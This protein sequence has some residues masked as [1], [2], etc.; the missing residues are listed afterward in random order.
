MRS[1]SSSASSSAWLMKTMATPFAFSRRISAKKW[2]FSS[3]VRLAVG[4]SKMMMRARISTARAI[5]TICFLA[6]PREATTA[7]GSTE[8]FSDCSACWAAMLMPRS[9]LK[10]RSRPR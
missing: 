1:A 8:K 7:A 5:S 4:S 3:G 2:C 9:R 10:K 6:A